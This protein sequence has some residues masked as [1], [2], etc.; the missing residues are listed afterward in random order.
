MKKNDTLKLTSTLFSQDL[1]LE[2]YCQNLLRN[3]K[4]LVVRYILNKNKSQT[5]DRQN[6]S[7]KRPSGVQKL[8][9][10]QFQKM[11]TF[12]IREE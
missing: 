5:K 9:D 8:D 6:S 3:L 7:I 12:K 11:T 4:T 10:V 1:T 2:T